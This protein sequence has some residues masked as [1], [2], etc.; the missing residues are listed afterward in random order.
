MYLII[1]V[2]L[3]EASHF[4][5]GVVE[6]DASSMLR[7]DIYDACDDGRQYQWYLQWFCYT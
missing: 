4:P 2:L 5:A 1:V 3:T 6:E 7:V